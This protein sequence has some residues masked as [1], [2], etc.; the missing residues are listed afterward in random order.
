MGLNQSVLARTKVPCSSLIHI[1]NPTL[2]KCFEKDASILH[3]YLPVFGFLQQIL[4]CCCRGT[5]YVCCRFL[6]NFHSC[7]LSFARDKTKAFASV[8]LFHALLFLC[9]QM[10][11]RIQQ[12]VVASSAANT[13]RILKT[14]VLLS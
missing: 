11:Q 12:K 1:P 5:K 13:C 7:K 10:L 14:I 6:A 8:T 2:F 3:L 4:P 9:F